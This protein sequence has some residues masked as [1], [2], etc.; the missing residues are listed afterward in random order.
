MIALGCN[1]KSKRPALD[2]SRNLHLLRNKK[3][4][5]YHPNRDKKKKRILLPS[6]MR[7][8]KGPFSNIIQI[9]P[10]K[11]IQNIVPQNT[12]SR[13]SHYSAPTRRPDPASGA[14]IQGQ[15]PPGKQNTKQR[16]ARKPPQRQGA[17]KSARRVEATQESIPY[18]T[19]R[20]RT[21]HRVVSSPPARGC[22]VPC[23]PARAGSPRGPG[24]RKRA[25]PAPAPAA[26]AAGGVC[27]TGRKKGAAAGL[28]DSTRVALRYF[29]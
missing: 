27:G 8:R 17:Q 14:Q 28:P 11:Q 13:K 5:F 23:L 10:M 20:A 2:L 25:A 18:L 29:L 21:E 1:L 3:H 22:R 26:A 15:I 9:K 7:G 12:A 24:G 16:E 4:K 6:R 19:L